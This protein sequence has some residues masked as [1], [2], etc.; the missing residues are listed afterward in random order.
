MIKRILKLTGI[1]AVICI[2]IFIWLFFMSLI[3]NEEI[4][5]GVRLLGFIATI[6]WPVIVFI[7]LMKY[8]SQ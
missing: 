7:G 5:T 2:L 3:M 1:F 8:E 6:A 4:G